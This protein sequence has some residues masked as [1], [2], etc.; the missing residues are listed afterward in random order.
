MMSEDRNLPP[1][2]NGTYAKSPPTATRQFSLPHPKAV[3]V[4]PATPI[5]N[6]NSLRY[7]SGKKRLLSTSVTVDPGELSV[8]CPLHTYR[9]QSSWRSDFL[10]RYMRFAMSPGIWG[11]RYDPFI[12]RLSELISKE[13]RK[14]IFIFI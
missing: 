12:A 13:K 8:G 14:K 5:A 11:L 6:N 3:E 10:V 9:R 7:R 1:E 4:T 2:I